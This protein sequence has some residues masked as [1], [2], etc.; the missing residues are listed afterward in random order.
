MIPDHVVGPAATRRALCV[1]WWLAG[2]LVPLAP[3][4]A[5]NAAVP[6]EYEI[7]AAFLFNFAKYSEWPPGAFARQQFQF[8][9]AQQADM[10]V[11]LDQKLS[12]QRVHGLPI[13][14]TQLV[15]D[16]L[17]GCHLVFVSA[18]VP[19]IRQQQMLNQA[20]PASIL[21]VGES[22]DFL[23]HG[24]DINFFLGGGT[25]HF[26]VDLDNLH[27]HRLTLS[28]KLLRHADRV[29]GKLQNDIAP[30]KLDRG[31]EP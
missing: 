28:S 16:M 8:C 5:G 12:Q 18:A 19:V 15:D 26:E 27:R 23:A 2:S 21:F 3:V 7:K 9:V 25:V 14:V 13:Q 22:P 6:R 10:A 29:L 17:S 30:A 11:L 24:G 4:H 20:A 1:L 31:S